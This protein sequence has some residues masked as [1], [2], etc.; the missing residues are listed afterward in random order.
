MNAWR[1]LLC[2]AILVLLP[3]AHSAQ[4]S[5]RPSR[6]PAPLVVTVSP[7]GPTQ[8]AIDHARAVAASHPLVRQYLDQTANRL[9]SFD[10]LESSL[11][12][13]PPNGFQATFFDY[14]ND[15]AIVATGLIE[16]PESL[17][18]RVSFEQPLPSRE[19]FDA[20][21]AVVERDPLLGPGLADGTLEPYPP[22]PPVLETA[23]SN[24]L[25]TVTVG[26]RSTKRLSHEIVGV[27]L[28][29]DEVVRFANGAPPAAAANSSQCGIPNAGQPTTPRGTAGQ[30]QVT[31]TQGP[32]TLWSMLVT[33]PAA[34][35]GTRASGVEVQNVD[36][37]GKRV[38]K[39]G[40]VPI[41]NVK[42]VNNGCGPYRDWQWQEGRFQAD[43]TDV[44][45]GIR[46]TVDPA[47]TVLDNGT[48]VG[49]FAG[50][51]YYTTADSLVLVSEMEAGWYRYIHEWHFENNGTIRPRFRF[52]GTFNSCICLTHTHHAYFR[53]DFDIVTSNK[54]AIYE[55]NG[56]WNPIRRNTEMMSLRS[57]TGNRRWLVEN[58]ASGEKYMIVP[59]EHDGLTDTY[60]R[61]DLWL[62]AY[63][64][65][66]LDDG[67]NSTGGE[68][69]AQL[70]K[71]LN[72]ESLN[73]DLVVWYAGHSVHEGGHEFDDAVHAVGPD[74]VPVVW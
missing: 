72:G 25:R 18:V 69:E 41:L 23:T 58:T 9:L 15:R 26:L 43:G 60:G 16:R 6:E 45:P 35:S 50:V 24:D 33:R 20:A 54:N 59:R 4:V 31:V 62:L 40:H 1:S 11:Q 52:G 64:S 55:V 71:F 30:F 65:N 46:N 22:M 13:Q 8:S 70:N 17:A 36:Y 42:Y 32:T 27:I 21:L 61:G 53:F 56:R 19:E 73:G 44:A 48:D 2:I 51:A 38:L 34:S 37:L 49:N 67:H 57:A 12:G 28:A 39:R 10:L 29:R 47:Q 3:T 68:T 14:T 5:G 66:E 63:G 74:L 7:W